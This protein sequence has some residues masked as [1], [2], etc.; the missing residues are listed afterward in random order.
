MKCHP[1]TL[2]PALRNALTR[3]RDQF[4]LQ[5]RE[6]HSPVHSADSLAAAFAVGTM[7]S[8]IPV[9]VLDTIL[10]GLVLSRY[11]GLN[12]A[13]IFLARLI[14]NDLLVFPL[15]GPG[16]KLGSTLILPIIG[17]DLEIPGLSVPALPFLGFIIGAVILSVSMALAGYLA[18]LIGIKVYR[19]YF[20]CD[21][22]YSC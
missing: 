11:K 20:E 2:F 16:Y 15:Y 5:L 19:A 3:A 18:F 12:R 22:T 14:W 10:V 4:W 13:S 8:F 21:S 6:L 7:L 17:P 9:P 1:C